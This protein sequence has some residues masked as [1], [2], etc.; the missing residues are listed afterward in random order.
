MHE[1]ALETREPSCVT[2]AAKP[3]F[4]PVVYSLSGTVRHMTAPELPSQEGRALSHGT[5]VSTGASL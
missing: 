1:C 3:F 2:R 4:I 5:R